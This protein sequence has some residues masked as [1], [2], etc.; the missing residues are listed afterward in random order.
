[1][2]GTRSPPVRDS[3]G[4]LSQR[5][6][7]DRGGDRV[8]GGIYPFLRK[9][10]HSGSDL[11]VTNLILH[12]R[13]GAVMSPSARKMPGKQGFDMHANGIAY[14]PGGYGGSQETFFVYYVGDEDKEKKGLF[15]IYPIS[16]IQ[17]GH[18]VHRLK[19]L[20]GLGRL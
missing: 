14:L 8:T 1:V 10:R 16:V 5:E 9:W 6:H 15:N 20:C 11:N 3:S 19:L 2:G 18:V 7:T 17:K 4:K 13:G 12:S